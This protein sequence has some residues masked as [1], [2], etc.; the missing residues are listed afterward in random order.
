MERVGKPLRCWSYSLFPSV[1][2]EDLATRS[3]DVR[4]TSAAGLFPRRQHKSTQ[5][6]SVEASSMPA[7]RATS[8]RPVTPSSTLPIRTVTGSSQRPSH[9]SE[10]SSTLTP[11]LRSSGW[12]ASMTSSRSEMGLWTTQRSWVDT[13]V[14]SPRLQ[15]S[16]LG[17]LY[18]SDLC[19]TTLTKGRGFLCAMRSSKLGQSS[20]SGTLPAPPG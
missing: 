14:T 16:L 1:F 7:G 9:R 15:S 18:R 5:Y 4:L 6:Q 20:A 8:R 19:R 10:S 2:K 13:A 17:R 12:T 11:T 3:Q